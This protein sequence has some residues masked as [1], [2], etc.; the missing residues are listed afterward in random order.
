VTRIDGEGL[1]VF[2]PSSAEGIDWFGLV[3]SRRSVREYL[4]TL[5]QAAWRA[6]SEVVPKFVSGSDP[7]A[8]WTGAY[9]GHAFFATRRR[10]CG[11]R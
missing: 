1:R 4:A 3:V 9:K 6:A 8:Q 2:R 5:G 7:A 11:D 10:Q